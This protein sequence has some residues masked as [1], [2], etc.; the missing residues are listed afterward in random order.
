MGMDPNLR[1]SLER[2]RAFAA[3]GEIQIKPL[4]L[5]VGEN[6]TGKTSFLAAL[7]F[8]LSLSDREKRGYFN[9]YPFDLGSFDDIAYDAT[10]ILPFAPVETGRWSCSSA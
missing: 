1:I 5:L 6:S 7:R 2:F 10:G 3:T 4:T 9:V 8:A